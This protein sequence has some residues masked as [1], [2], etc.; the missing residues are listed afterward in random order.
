MK[1]VDL[2]KQLKYIKETEG[3]LDVYIWSDGIPKIV[4]QAVKI[5]THDGKRK[6]CFLEL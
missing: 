1:I 5:E 4:N 3:N 6:G 2:I